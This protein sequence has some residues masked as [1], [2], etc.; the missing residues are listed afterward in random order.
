MTETT[1]TI[2]SFTSVSTKPEPVKRKPKT[3]DDS[4][5]TPEQIEAAQKKEQEIKERA[6][7]AAEERKETEPKLVVQ[8]GEEKK[9]T[10]I[11][12]I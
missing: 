10:S 4:K 6:K 7:R 12:M 5:R 1:K 3:I 11:D 8:I 2:K 9:H